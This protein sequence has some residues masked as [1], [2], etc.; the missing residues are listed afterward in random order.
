[1]PARRR[2]ALHTQLFVHR[3]AK[4]LSCQSGQRSGIR[5]AQPYGVPTIPVAVV[6]TSFDRGGTERQMTELVRR[7]DRTRFE[8]HVACFRR[9]GPWLGDVTTAAASVAEFRLGSLASPGACRQVWRMAAWLQERRVTVLQACDVYAN[10]VALPAAAL[11]RVPVR[12]G[13]RRGIVSPTSQKGLLL[14][15]RAGYATAHRIVANSE[16]AAAR[17]RREGVSGRRVIVIPNGIDLSRFPA[18]GRRSRRVITT[19]ANLRPGK[20]HE[21]LLGAVARL[22]RTHPDLRLQVIGDGPL[23]RAL[24]ARSRALNIADRVVFLGHQDDIPR[25]LGESGV[26]VLPSFMEAFP[27]SVMEAM[28]AGLPVVATRVGG[29]P[30]L[31]SDGRDGLLVP[32]GDEAALAAAIARVLDDPALADALGDAARAAIRARFSFERTV[33]A[34]ERLYLDLLA[35]RRPARTAPHQLG[36]ASSDRTTGR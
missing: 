15:Q 20:G 29:I 4:R 8:V 32:A 5:L 34:F 23:R 14:L 1:V 36:A 31:V 6:L 12:V 30:E 11:A 27:N 7:L 22:A 33:A 24:D 28:A 35:A 21:V 16:A 9:E 10:I 17:L 3:A 26:F 2:Y 18:A 13:S 25:R 19:V